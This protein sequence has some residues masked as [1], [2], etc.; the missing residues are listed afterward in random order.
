MRNALSSTLN[1]KNLIRSKWKGKRYQLRIKEVLRIKDPPIRT[2][3][4][5]IK[6]FLFQLLKVP[7]SIEK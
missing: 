7:L 3:K 5:R 6:S 2:K 1:A 4:M